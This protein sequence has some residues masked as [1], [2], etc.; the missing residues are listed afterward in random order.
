MRAFILKLMQKVL[1]L[2]KRFK[3]RIF[4]IYKLNLYSNRLKVKNDFV[5]G[6]SFEI[7]FDLSKSRIQIGSNVEFRNFCQLRSGMDGELLIGNRVFFNNNC[8]IN[9]MHLV[10]IG[11]DCQFG[12]G[13]KFYDHNHEFRLSDKLINEQGY[14]FGEIKI[15]KNCWFGSNVIILKN[16][17]IGDNVVV[18]A[19]CVIHKSIPSNSVVKNSQNFIVELK[20]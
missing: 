2:L 19:G 5:F 14:I 16:V 3:K 18:G 10:S 12:E 4:L 6:D 7:C 17:E 11:D 9:S 15:G 8:S 20:Q 13:V 1:I